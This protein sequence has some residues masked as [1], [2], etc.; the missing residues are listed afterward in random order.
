[1]IHYKIKFIFFINENNL[2]E[3]QIK[4]AQ[5]YF[6]EK[7]SPSLGVIVLNKFR[8]IPDFKENLSILM[9]NMELV[10]KTVQNGI[11]HIPKDLQIC[12]VAF[13]RFK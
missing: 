2:Y 1:M 12:G 11:I 6:F 10:D 13:Q 4:F 9:V 7:V 5:E 3:Y 8:K